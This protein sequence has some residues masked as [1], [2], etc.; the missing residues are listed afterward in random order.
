MLMRSLFIMEMWQGTTLW[1][2]CTGIS[3]NPSGTGTIGSVKFQGLY[4][5]SGRSKTKIS[6]IALSKRNKI[7]TNVNVSCVNIEVVS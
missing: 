1:V 2:P 3:R 7:C 6:Q 5:R 4:H